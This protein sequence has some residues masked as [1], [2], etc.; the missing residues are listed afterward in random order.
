MNIATIILFL[1]WG[2]LA[3]F[4]GTKQGLNTAGKILK[5]DAE[6]YRKVKEETE[7]KLSQLK[8]ASDDMVRHSNSVD[9]LLK[10]ADETILELD[11]KKYAH[12]T[13]PHK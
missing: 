12:N 5:K 10:L 6:M 4:L 1:V 2:I 11:K 9:Q 3:F 7:L 8:T 13:A